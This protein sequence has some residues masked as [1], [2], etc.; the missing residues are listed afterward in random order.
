MPDR[1]PRHRP[2]LPPPTPL[3][4]GARVGAYEVRHVLGGGSTGIVY[5]VYDPQTDED[6]ALREYLPPALAVR[7][8][9]FAVAVRTPRLAEAFAE[10]LRLFVDEGRTLAGIDHPGL[11]K[12]RQTWEEH[13]TAY[14]VMELVTARDLAVLQQ[15]RA[16]P[17]REAS[18]RPLLAALL[19]AAEALHEA[20]LQHG[21]I[22]PRNI[23]VEPSGRVLLLDRACARGV[24]R[25]VPEAG[26]GG[27][28]EGYAAPEMYA[29][30]TAPRGPWSD[31][32][33]LGAVVYFIIAGRAPPPA[34]TR[35]AGE[36]LA[37][38][39]RKKTEHRYSAAFLAVVDRMLAPNPADRPQTIAELRAALGP[40]PAAAHAQA[41]AAAAAPRRGRR[42]LWWGLGL[43]TVFG[44]AAATVWFLQRSGRLPPLPA[45][46]S[47]P[48][49]GR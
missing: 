36:A 27:P 38:P 15:M 39:L 41:G 35:R 24:L 45:W 21:D 6:L 26:L 34:P 17:P 20:G 33:S 40:A 43:L 7:N 18:L 16:R 23:L 25:A 42:W 12:V 4:A 3:P 14:T 46:L 22:T 5:R 19:D 13:G 30:S 44:A 11:V 10:G 48:R 28:R 9:P 47:L 2:P 37:A 49:F 1:R 8:G 29:D 31:V 32:Y